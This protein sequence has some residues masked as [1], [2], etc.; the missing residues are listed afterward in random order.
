MIDDRKDAWC[1]ELDEA[2]RWQVYNA[3]AAAKSWEA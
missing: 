2:R 1:A 3:H